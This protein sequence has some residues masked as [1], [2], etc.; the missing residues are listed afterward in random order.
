MERSTM[1][2]EDWSE[3]RSDESVGQEIIVWTETHF[4][5]VVE[6]EDQDFGLFAKE[7]SSP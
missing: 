4:S 5:S 3:R 6:T 2:E 7:E 1:T